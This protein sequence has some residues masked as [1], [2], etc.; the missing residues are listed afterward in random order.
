MDGLGIQQWPSHGLF[1]VILNSY[2][3]I[4][5]Q[6]SMLN[7]SNFEGNDTVFECHFGA[8]AEDSAYVSYNE[9]THNVVLLDVNPI[10]I[11]E[12]YALNLNQE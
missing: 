9:N 2:I 1:A 5:K 8:G 4:P 10:T 6:F 12:I 11:H 3:C 7:L